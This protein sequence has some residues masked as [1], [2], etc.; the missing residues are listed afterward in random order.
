MS[1]SNKKQLRKEQGAGKLTEKQLAAQKEATT[2]RLYTV[3]FVVVLVILLAIAIFVGVSQ[4]IKN[5]GYR[6]KHTVAVQIGDHSLSNADLNYFFID[7]VN[8]FY[9]NYGSYAG[10]FGLDTSKPLDQQV[11]DEDSGTTWADD[12][13]ESAKETARNVY[14]LADAAEAAGFTLPEDKAE[15]LEQNLNSIDTYAK[16]YGYQTGDAYLKAMYG[17]GA[18]KEGFREYSTR[19]SLADAYYASYSDSLTYSDAQIAE[20]NAEDPNAY[21]SYSYHSYYM[22]I[23]KFR[24]GGTEDADGNTTYTDEETAAAEAALR[25]AAESLVSDEITTTEE[26]D[27]AIAALS[28]NEGEDSAA[29]TNSANIRYTS[30][31][32]LYQ[33]WLSDS[34]RKAG[35]RQ[36]FESTTTNEDGTETLNGCYV[37]YY[38]AT[39]D[40]EFK[41]VNVRHIL[42][43]PDHP[44]DEADDAHADGET[45]SDEEIAAARK[46]A[47]EIYAEWKAGEATEDSFAELANEKSDDGDGTTGGL[48]QN[49]I[50]GQ[51]VQA[52]NDWC[53]DPSRQSGDTG[54]VDTQYGSHIMYFVGLSDITYRTSLIQSDLRTADVAAWQEELVSALTI[55]DGDTSYIRTD[56][57][58]NSNS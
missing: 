47:E 12:F 8:T 31:N 30:L 20:K 35:D 33:D 37:I 5:S 41:M 54:I 10:M 18:S 56:L 6:E 29:S 38:D 28:I 21:S 44:T 4:T 50:P 13:M 9:S 51:M 57:V 39:S 19:N 52:F 36:V 25:A 32:S 24:T 3:A 14:A 1:A 53:F 16:L 58:I 49:V 40:N 7:A 42:V 17:K 26:L 43:K 27:A 2:T 11:T 46:T 22:P 15:E 48:Y 34:S 23:S 55:T 45:Y